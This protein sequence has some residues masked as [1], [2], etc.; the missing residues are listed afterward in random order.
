MTPAGTVLGRLSIVTTAPEPDLTS[1][2]RQGQLHPRQ[3]GGGPDPICGTIGRD[4]MN[5]TEPTEDDVSRLA[6]QVVVV[7]GLAER[8]GLPTLTGTEADLPTLQAILDS[9]ELT[10]D[11]TYE[12]QSL[13]VAFGRV[14]ITKVDGLDWAIIN[15]EYGSDP[16]VR[17]RNTTLCVNALTAISKRVENGEEV[18]VADLLRSFEG[19][20]Q[21]AILHMGGT[22]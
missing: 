9:G 19:G 8:L 4:P 10:A 12:L 6:Q 7:S 17:Y 13:G 3:E 14:L 11:D 1:Y 2:L 22:A 18:D 21:E 15:D 20:I 5:F 16:T